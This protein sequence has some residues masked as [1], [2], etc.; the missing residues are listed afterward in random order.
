MNKEILNKAAKVLT[1]YLTDV[2]IK[3]LTLKKLEQSVK[4][5]TEHYVLETELKKRIKTGIEGSIQITI[6][7]EEWNWLNVVQTALSQVEK[8]GHEGTRS[9]RIFSENNPKAHAALRTLCENVPT[10]GVN[11]LVLTVIS[12]YYKN[13]VATASQTKWTGKKIIFHLVERYNRAFVHVCAPEKQITVD[14]ITNSP[15]IET[16]KNSF[17]WESTRET[18][19]ARCN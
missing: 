13:V 18:Q 9:I 14:C 12:V 8:M 7:K 19:L 15:L 10:Q 6:P 16:I 5:D 1:R 17:P 3:N 11:C 4:I 2:S